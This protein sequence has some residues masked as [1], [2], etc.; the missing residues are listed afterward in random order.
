MDACNCGYLIDCSEIFN[1]RAGIYN[2]QVYNQTAIKS[3]IEMSLEEQIIHLFVEADGMQS[4]RRHALD[5]RVPHDMQSRRRHA[6]NSRVPHDMQS[7]RRHA[8]EYPTTCSLIE[9]MH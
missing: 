3:C 5:S 9:D 7:R 8:L 1:S 6:L 4:R 2:E